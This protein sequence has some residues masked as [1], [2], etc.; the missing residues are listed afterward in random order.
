MK[1]LIIDNNTN[2][3]ACLC[4]V[5]KDIGQ[6]DVVGGGLEGL[7]C[8]A[9]HLSKE[10]PYNLIFL[11]IMLP[12]IDGLDL[13][14]QIRIL[15]ESFGV[16][17]EK[18]AIVVVVTFKKDEPTILKGFLNGAT[19]WFHKPLKQEFVEASIKKLIK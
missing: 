11:D 15:E 2:P 5:L 17:P 12:D 16:T 6:C 14:K 1:T 10:E 13:I 4:K 3:N 7:K 9:E 8:L 18:E 19:G